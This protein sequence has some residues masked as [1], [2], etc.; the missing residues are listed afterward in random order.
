[1]KK[2]LITVI[3]LVGG[4]NAY[5]QNNKLLWDY[6]PELRRRDSALYSYYLRD[7]QRSGN[8]LNAA[9]A[10]KYFF[11]NNSAEMYYDYEAYNMDDNTY[12]PVTLAKEI[13]PIYRIKK[14]DVYLLCY[15]RG[16]ENGNSI[17]LSIYDNKNDK[18]GNAFV[19]AYNAEDDF[20]P[21]TIGCIF[22]NGY[23]ATVE[24]QEE[25]VN[26]VYYVLSK[27]DYENRK[28]VELKRIKANRADMDTHSLFD[29]NSFKVLG[30]SE[31]GELLGR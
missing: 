22:P 27:I 24:C 11:N 20:G 7:I 14:Q 15:G 6:F 10:L 31:K 28:F 3:A 25:G 19:V 26:F 23:I 2:I 17:Y 18:I 13:N 9:V 5:C 4:L 16:S 29:K 1:M 8:P 21:Y 12:T 30:I